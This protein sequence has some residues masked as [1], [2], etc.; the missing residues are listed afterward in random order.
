MSA[1]AAS[2]FVWMILLPFFFT[3]ESALATVAGAILFFNGSILVQGLIVAK[4]ILS[5]GTDI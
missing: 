2:S 5:P 1:A 3:V 4:V